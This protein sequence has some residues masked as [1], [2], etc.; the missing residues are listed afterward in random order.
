MLYI[1]SSKIRVLA[2]VAGAEDGWT[3]F[4]P[5]YLVPCPLWVGNE[6][7]VALIQVAVYGSFAFLNRGIIAVVDDG[8]RHPAENRFD[9]IKKLC[10][11]RK[12]DKRNAWRV[13]AIAILV[14]IDPRNLLE[15]G[16]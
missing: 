13:M 5:P 10:G 12:R 4:L 8:S 9:H 1:S 3:P 2:I 16:T 7:L 6:K 14:V 15:K 11:C